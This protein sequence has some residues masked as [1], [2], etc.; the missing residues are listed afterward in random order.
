MGVKSAK[1]PNLSFG[2]LRDQIALLPSCIALPIPFLDGFQIHEWSYKIVKPT[3]AAK[4]S[5]FGIGAHVD[6]F[7]WCKKEHL[8]WGFGGIQIGHFHVI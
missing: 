3:A 2:S 5:H 6:L 8:T 7:R 1:N 4:K